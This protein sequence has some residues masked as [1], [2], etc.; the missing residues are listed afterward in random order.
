MSVAPAIAFEETPGGVRLHLTGVWTIEAGAKL[1]RQANAILGAAD[2]GGGTALIDLSELD[3]MDTA[4]AWLIDRSRQTLEAH[5]VDAEIVGARLEHTILLHE[6]RFRP[7]DTPARVV[8]PTLT[9]LLADVGSSVYGA[10]SDVINGVAF[11]GRLVSDSFEVLVHPLR[12]RWT[13]TA[14]HLESFALRGAPIILLITFLVGAI[15]A[16]QG[17]FQLQRFN[18]TPYAVD[19]IGLLVLRELGVLLTSIMIAGR[20]GSSI[21]AEIGAMRMREE[22]DAMIVM[23]LDPIEVLI[24]P[25]IMALVLALPLLTFLADMAALFGG[26]CVAWVYGDISPH[27]FIGRL[28]DAIAFNTFAV[29]LIKAPFMGLTIGLIAAVEGFAVAGSAESL[30]SRVTDSVVKSIFMVIVLDGLFAMFFAAVRY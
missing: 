14:H 20:S 15:V 11:L 21:T 1:E 2:H 22:V 7:T 18:A 27:V 13:S 9:S 8:H 26:A 6:A 12:W 24:L 17:I 28:Q 16:Q 23:A 19:L 5:G 10:G 29:G 25:R 3:H 30:G 4:G